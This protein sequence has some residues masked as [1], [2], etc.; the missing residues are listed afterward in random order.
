MLVNEAITM[1]G[2]WTDHEGITID[3]IHEISTFM[4]LIQASTEEFLN[5]IIVKKELE[6]RIEE[7]SL[8]IFQLGRA[9]GRRNILK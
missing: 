3:N 1:V 7:I 4:G 9:V 2:E 5:E 6:D 8:A